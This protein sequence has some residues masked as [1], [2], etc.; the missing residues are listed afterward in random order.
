MGAPEN[1]IADT[2]SDAA[3]SFDSIPSPTTLSLVYGL[4]KE[5]EE[6]ASKVTKPPIQII[7]QKEQYIALNENLL[8]ACLGNYI[9]SYDLIFYRRKSCTSA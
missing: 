4:P 3:N 7:D 8:K 1:S 2:T 5:K 9:P 6:E